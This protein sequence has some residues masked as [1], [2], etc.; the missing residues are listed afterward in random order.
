MSRQSKRAAAYRA[1]AKA[2]CLD[3]ARTLAR[4]Q[5]LGFHMFLSPEGAYRLDVAAKWFAQ[6]EPT[7]APLNAEAMHANMT[8][9]ELGYFGFRRADQKPTTLGP[10]D[11]YEPATNLALT[12]H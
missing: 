12:V 7:G 2:L 5:H 9:G 4:G 10:E 8:T 6:K 1:A 11:V 3:Y